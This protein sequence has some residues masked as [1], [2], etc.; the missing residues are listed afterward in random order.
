MAIP[1][2]PIGQTVEHPNA[3]LILTFG[4]L[5]LCC[6]VFGPVAWVMG[7]KALNEIDNSYGA[8]S[9]RTQVFIGYVIGIIGTILVVIM[10]LLWL[11]VMCNGG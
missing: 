1:N 9:G 4:I 5:S 3:N 11:L 7:K 2:Q 6:G 10:A 8:Y